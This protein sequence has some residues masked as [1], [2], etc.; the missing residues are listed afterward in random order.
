[1]I[2]NIF[3]QIAYLTAMMTSLPSSAASKTRATG[4]KVSKRLF[5]EKKKQKT[6][7]LGAWAVSP[8]E[9]KNK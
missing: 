5:F 7:V 2:Y 9:A 4:E 8:P 6:F 3:Q 1:M